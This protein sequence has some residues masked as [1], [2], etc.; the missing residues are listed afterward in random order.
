MALWRV[1]SRSTTSEV[2][3]SVENPHQYIAL[4][5]HHFLHCRHAA[6]TYYRHNMDSIQLNT[7]LTTRHNLRASLS[8]AIEI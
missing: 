1:R 5:S 6:D 8:P 4:T 7:L 2:I 3:I